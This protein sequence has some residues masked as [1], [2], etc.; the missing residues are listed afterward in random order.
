MPRPQAAP[1]FPVQPCRPVCL[2]CLPT[3]RFAGPSAAFSPGGDATEPSDE[4]RVSRTRSL[5]RAPRRGV[6]LTGFL[7]PTRVRSQRQ[8]TS[9]EPGPL[10]MMVRFNPTTGGARMAMQSALCGLALATT[11]A[12][13]ARASA[14]PAADP[15]HRDREP[16][17]R[18]RAPDLPC[19][20]PRLR[21]HQGA[22]RAER[23]L[24]R[25][26]ARWPQRLRPH[27]H[28]DAGA[29]AQRGDRRDRT[30]DAA[31]S[32]AATWPPCAHASPRTRRAHCWRRSSA[33]A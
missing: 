6:A 21:A 17:Q 4:R 13:A 32:P 30:R 1:I 10:Q 11:L 19:G 31:T 22:H 20:R 15:R 2:N 8:K 12:S 33:S 16:A 9:T 3:R 7:T 27:R 23:R 29:D 14:E 5:T 26:R 25:L 18:L 24:Q 28:A